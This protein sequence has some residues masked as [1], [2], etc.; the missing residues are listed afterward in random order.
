[1]FG[2]EWCTGTAREVGGTLTA[3]NRYSDFPE[4]NCGAGWFLNSQYEIEHSMLLAK[5]VDHLNQHEFN[6]EDDGKRTM[7]ITHGREHLDAGDM[8]LDGEV[9]VRTDGFRELDTETGDVLFDWKT[10][11]YIS[12]NESTYRSPKDDDEP[13]P[14][15]YS[16]S[17]AWDA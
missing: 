13:N 12:L 5:D 6:I 15:E 9:W 16:R 7:I 14:G 8:G 10:Q 17:G 3:V 4:R 11:D 2:V 1:M